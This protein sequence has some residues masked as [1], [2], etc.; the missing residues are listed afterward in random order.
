MRTGLAPPVYVSA[1][2]WYWHLWQV[3]ARKAHRSSWVH[4]RTWWWLDVDTGHGGGHQ[5][6]GREMW[7]V[8][9]YVGNVE[10]GTKSPVGE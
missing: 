3:N 6:Q 7:A 2:W 10:L 9:V 5:G 8:S 1:Q 4:S